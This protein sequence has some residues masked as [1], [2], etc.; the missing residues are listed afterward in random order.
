MIGLDQRLPRL[1]VVA[2]QRRLGLRR[3]LEHRRNVGGEVRRGVR[4]RQA[5]LQRR[6]GVDHA[7]RN[8]VVA[9]LEALLERGQ[10]LVHRAFLHEDLGAA[11]PHHHQAR[12]VVLLLEVADV[13]DQLIGEILLVLAF[14]DVRARQALHVALIEHRG[15]RL[16]RLELRT[17]RIEQR[18]F[19]HAGRAGRGVAV[20][21]EDVPAAEHDVVELRER[22]ELV[23]LRGAVV[24]AL[25][26]T[27][28]AHLRERSN[29]LRETLADGNDA[30]DG[31]GADR[32]EPDEED[33]QLAL[34]RG[35]F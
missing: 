2:G 16:D 11:A 22:H 26:E 35:D 19:E 13:G 6:V 5:F 18:A 29:G 7:R 33:A 1:H 23:D 34:G 20:F 25:A 4:E 17:D 12:A 3:E 9:Q 8:R 10:R 21:F 14:L 28:R 15:H 27:D 30:G 31:G 32:A 24:G